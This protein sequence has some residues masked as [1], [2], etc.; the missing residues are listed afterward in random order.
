MRPKGPKNYYL[1]SGPPT[2]PPHPPP[3]SPPALI[4]GSGLPG[5]LLSEGLELPL[6]SINQLCLN[7]VSDKTDGSIKLSWLYQVH[8]Y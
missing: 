1:R 8:G 3:P 2:P 6:Q 7:T 5:P 4:S